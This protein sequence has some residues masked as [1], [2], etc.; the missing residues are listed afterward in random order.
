MLNAE[1]YAEVV[2]R[3]VE[4]AGDLA[5]IGALM[6]SGYPPDDARRR[7]RAR[8]SPAVQFQA[9]LGG[10]WLA[11]RIVVITQLAENLDRGT[12]E[13]A[14]TIVP[15]QWWEQRLGTSDPTEPGWNAP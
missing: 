6:D 8:S 11:D 4:L 5:Y 7:S 2:D 1:L 10:A 15:V 13:L 12:L 3:H 14:L 9:D